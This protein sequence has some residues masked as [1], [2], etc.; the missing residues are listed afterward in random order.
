MRRYTQINSYQCET[1]FVC[2][3]WNAISICWSTV[4]SSVYSFK[5]KV[6]WVICLFPLNCSLNAHKVTQVN[7]IFYAFY[8]SHFNFKICELVHFILVY[9][10]LSRRPRNNY[11]VVRSSNVEQ[12]G[13]QRQYWRLAKFEHILSHRIEMFN[14]YPKKFSKAWPYVIGFELFILPRNYANFN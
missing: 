2:F 7:W 6:A 8:N 3:L 14:N 5:W 11:V 4:R 9:L 10:F 1:T 12:V 13:K